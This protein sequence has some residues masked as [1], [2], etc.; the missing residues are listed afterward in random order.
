MPNIPIP[1]PSSTRIKLQFQIDFITL[2]QL[3]C[4]IHIKLYIPSRFKTLSSSSFSLRFH[5]GFQLAFLCSLL[6]LVSAFPFPFKVRSFLI[7]ACLLALLFQLIVI[8]FFTSILKFL[9]SASFNTSVLIYPFT[10]PHLFFALRG[11]PKN[12]QHCSNNGLSG[13]DNRN[14]CT[15]DSENFATLICFE[16]VLMNSHELE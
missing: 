14:K 4:L 11:A 1:N 2:P 13:E 5:C 7:S 10:F 16:P 8:H 9:T 3:Q 6:T 15:K 12:E